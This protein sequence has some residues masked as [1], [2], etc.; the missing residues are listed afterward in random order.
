MPPAWRRPSK[1]CATTARRSPKRWRRDSQRWRPP[2]WRRSPTGR[3]SITTPT[4]SFPAGSRCRSPSWMERGLGSC[5][6]A[7]ITATRHASTPSACCRG[8]ARWIS[9]P[10]RPKRW[11]RPAAQARWGAMSG[12]AQAED[13]RPRVGHLGPAGSF[14]EEALLESAKPGSVQPVA[15]ETI[16]DTAMALIR[17]EVAWAVLPIENSLD[18]SVTV[19]LDLLADHAGEI[20]VVSEQLLAVRHCLAAGTETPLARI[21]TVLTHPQVPGPCRRVLRERLPPARVVPAS[22]TAEAV[23]KAAEAAPEEGLAAIGT[24]LGGELYGARVLR[25]G[26]PDRHGQLT[27]LVGAGRRSGE[28]DR[29]ASRPPLVKTDGARSKTSLVFWGPGADRAGWLVLCLDQFAHRGINLT[30]IESRPRRE[31]MGHYMFFVDLEG[32]ASEQDVAEADPPSWGLR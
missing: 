15:L 3:S 5:S 9:L 26:G 2:C 25:A 4:T 10:R 31:R 7:S 24:R 22:S 29:A 21:G 28:Q 17:G 20:E 6:R 11:R 23:R 14:T 18:G 13:A 1:R 27:R 30:K 16:Y 32:D 8:S 12:S 19:T